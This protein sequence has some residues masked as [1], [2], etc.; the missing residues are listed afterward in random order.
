MSQTAGGERGGGTVRNSYRAR[1]ER[2]VEHSARTRSLFLGLVGAPR[3]GFTPGQ[4]ISISIPL[5]E[6]SRVRAYSIASS[7][8]EDGPLE[9][10]LDLV[11]GGAGSRWLFDCR[12]G[13]HLEFT[14][15]Y[16]T[17]TLAS[18]PAAETVFIAQGT[19]IAPIRPM[20]R[21][22]LASAPHPAMWLIH[23]AAEHSALL[24]R[25]E[26]ERMVGADRLFSFDPLIVAM[27]EGGAS[28]PARLRQAV[29]DRYVKADADRSRR[30]YICGVGAS[31]IELRDLL[32][33]AGYQ[34]RAVAYERW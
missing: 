12:V 27:A 3:F 9:I 29:E 7:P 2:I 26:F 21:R 14:G 24:F 10:C 16:G 11:P 13:D 17:F 20:I 6:G 28:C 1:I 32:R 34:R 23:A 18:A 5:A 8:E 15:P 4:F 33:G 19:A 22:A 31:V 25:A 30:F